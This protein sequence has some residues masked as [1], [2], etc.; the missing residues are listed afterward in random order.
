MWS[1]SLCGIDFSDNPDAFEGE[2]LVCTEC[3]DRRKLMVAAC[4]GVPTEE[5]REG[6]LKRAMQMLTGLADIDIDD[7]AVCWEA[8]ARDLVREARAMLGRERSDV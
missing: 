7:D 8:D 4:R 3:E 6:V 1:C 2:L 5:L